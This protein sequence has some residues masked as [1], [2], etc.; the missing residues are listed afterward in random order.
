MTI[1]NAGNVGIGTAAPSG[2]LHVENGASS[3]TLNDKADELVVE[4]L[5]HGGISILTPDAKEVNYILIMMLS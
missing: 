5:D 3:K 2:K 1:K 4:S